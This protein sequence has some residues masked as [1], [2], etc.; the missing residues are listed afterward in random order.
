MEELAHKRLKKT[1]LGRLVQVFKGRPVVK[2]D[3]PSGVR[4]TGNS[5]SE[6][7]PD[8][9]SVVPPALRISG[10]HEVTFPVSI[11]GGLLGMLAGTLPASAWVLLTGFSFP[12]LYALLPFFIYW[13][14]R[15]LKGYSGK[16]AVIMTGIFSAPSL[17][18]T[19][20]SCQAAAYVIKYHM[21]FFNVPLVTIL[22]I[23]KSGALPNP[24]ISSANVFPFIFTFFGLLLLKELMMKKTDS[25]SPPKT[26]AEKEAD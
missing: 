20:L 11:V 9:T 25:A 24:L 15:I 3:K 19:A 16:G 12:P 5:L 13:G 26:L 4:A 23:G 17:Y 1:F 21:L 14:I 8:D 2:R 22:L 18:L 6:A 7:R 10:K